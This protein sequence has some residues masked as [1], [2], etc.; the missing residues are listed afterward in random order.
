MAFAGIVSG[1]TTRAHE[2]S[3]VRLAFTIPSGG[4][5]IDSVHWLLTTTTNALI[6]QGD[7][8]T[9]DVN[10]TASVDVICPTGTGDLVTVSATASDGTSCY[11][12]SAPFDVIAGTP[13][14]VPVTVVCGGGAPTTTPG[15]VQVTG[16]IIVSDSCP[17][18]SNFLV[19]PKQ[20]S[21]GAAI[22]VGGHAADPDTG[23]VLTYSWTA[24]AGSFTDPTAASTQYICSTAGMQVITFT[25]DDNHSPTPCLATA[26]T[27]VTCVGP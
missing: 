24:T 26:Q 17:V 21:V 12:I 3:S 4:P 1:C 23:D 27:T 9:R 22:D 6:E 13:V 16:T 19:A 11:G 14:S 15:V 2:E 18:I 20:T 10:A 7:I 8:D 25:V 5:T